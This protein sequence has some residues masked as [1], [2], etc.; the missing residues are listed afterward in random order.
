MIER[1]S[2]GSPA[3]VSGTIGQPSTSA[4]ISIV[5]YGWSLRA[6]GESRPR[7]G[8]ETDGDVTY[9]LTKKIR[10]YVFEG[11]VPLTAGVGGTLTPPEPSS[12]EG[13]SE[14][15]VLQYDTSRT[16]T[17]SVIIDSIN[18]QAIGSAAKESTDEKWICTGSCHVVGEPVY[19]AGWGTQPGDT[20]PT[21]ADVTS[22]DG[23]T[24]TEDPATVKL[25]RG[26][27]DV[28][29]WWGGI[30]VSTDPA[31]NDANVLA[32]LQAAIAATAAPISGLKQRP[33]TAN[34]DA[35]D[36][37]T[38]E[39][40]W[41]MNDT[42][43]DVLNPHTTKFVDPNGFDTTEE[44]TALNATPS[45]AGTSGQVVRG[46]RF[47]KLNDGATQ[48]IKKNGVRSSIEDRTLPGTFANMDETGISSEASE[49][50][51]FD[52]TAVISPIVEL[53]VGT[54]QKIA[55]TAIIVYPG[56][57]LPSNI[58]AVITRA[59]TDSTGS[60][61][62]LALTR[63]TVNGVANALSV[64]TVTQGT[65]Y[66]A[67]P[68]VTFTGTGL[69]LPATAATH[70][71]KTV[72]QRPVVET[73]DGHGNIRWA[74]ASRDGVDER[75]LPETGES[76][77][78]SN[79]G[80]TY[81]LALVDCA[82]F[83]SMYTN[84]ASQTLSL[85]TV[86]KH[87]I[88]T[89]QTRAITSYLY[90]AVYTEL[91]TEEEIEQDG[92]AAEASFYSGVDSAILTEESEIVTCS[93]GASVESLWATEF[94]A[95]FGDASLV[96]LRAQK[97]NKTHVKFSYRRRNDDYMVRIE[98]VGTRRI[99]RPTD[100]TGTYVHIVDYKQ[101]VSGH[102]LYL[103]SP[104]YVEQTTG[105]IVLRRL[106]KT[107]PW[108]G[109][110]Q[111]SLLGKLNNG[112]FIGWGAGQLLYSGMDLVFNDAVDNE[113][114]DHPFAI[115]YRFDL[116]LFDGAAGHF[117]QNIPIEVWLETTATI[118]AFG[119]KAATTLASTFAPQGPSQAD[120]SPFLA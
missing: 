66:T 105:T 87:P 99:E 58:A 49:V 55:T 8:P 52:S 90:R 64:V 60:G 102:Y 61:A 116:E 45:A 41:G 97:L 46:T 120:F 9:R 68:I 98:G 101:L 42:N 31:T 6:K 107:H 115:D 25:G 78:Q 103:L 2:S 16:I 36:G 63:G 50:Q 19:S 32:R 30:T 22:Y 72:S 18:F 80:S 76:T 28:I 81:T 35:P 3:G 51:V 24:I 33:C 47:I 117:S 86:F 83:P 100:A 96:S 82:Y 10:N 113:G 43:D 44:T 118:S 53:T 37:G 67:K 38:F 70:K 1:G 65:L 23:S 54:D 94:A 13:A 79:I 27:R 112:D 73:H 91:T 108:T 4:K 106:I 92:T 59:G 40:P 39:I 62:S 17:A 14:T 7:Y 84:S 48:Q 56:Q 75:Q 20:S 74:F 110:K 111:N 29:D 5:A 21:K 11:V 93:S 85:R 95:Q 26:G 119:D 88:V 34:Q 57:N 12:W 69:L 77:D 109:L 15:L 71:L 114:N 104:R 89:S